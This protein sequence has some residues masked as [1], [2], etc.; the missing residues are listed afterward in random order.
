VGKSVKS[1]T[2]A[3][4]YEKALK[5]IATLRPFVDTFF[6]EVMVMVDDEAVK[7]NRM[8]LLSSVAELFQNIA[9]FT[10]I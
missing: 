9:D 4:E 7:Q 2:A 6:D 1:F 10:L 8:G 3:G 5:E